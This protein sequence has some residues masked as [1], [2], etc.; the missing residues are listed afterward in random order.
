[1]LFP[2]AHSPTHKMLCRPE[3][4]H[5]GGLYKSMNHCCIL[6]LLKLHLCPTQFNSLT[7]T[8]L[9]A[10]VTPSTVTSEHTSHLYTKSCRQTR[11]TAG[12]NQSF[13]QQKIKAI[14][15]SGPSQPPKNTS[16]EVPITFIIR[17]CLLNNIFWDSMFVIVT[18]NYWQSFSVLWKPLKAL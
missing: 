15:L 12:E 8:G 4:V 5:S 16:P 10:P 14:W 17:L 18:S 1:M 6:L 7:T 2:H 11:T 3:N 9:I 13:H